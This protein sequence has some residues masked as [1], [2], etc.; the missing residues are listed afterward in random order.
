MALLVRVLRN[1]TS[2]SQWVPV[3]SQLVS[4]SPTQRQWSSTSQGVRC[5]IHST[6]GF[7]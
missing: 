2:I 3:C 7:S 4:V 5:P 1:Q 6:P